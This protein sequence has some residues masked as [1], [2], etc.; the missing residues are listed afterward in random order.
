MINFVD[1]TINSL[2]MIEILLSIGELDG[3]L[4]NKNRIIII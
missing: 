2:T 1:F 3:E 4:A